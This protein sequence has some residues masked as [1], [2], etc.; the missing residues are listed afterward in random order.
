[1]ARPSGLASQRRISNRIRLFIGELTPL[2]AIVLTIGGLTIDIGH[3]GAPS[4]TASMA[5]AH[6]IGDHIIMA[7]VRTGAPMLTDSMV[8]APIMGGIARIGDIIMVIIPIGDTGATVFMVTL[9]GG[10]TFAA[11]PHAATSATG[12]MSPACPHQCVDTCPR[13][14]PALAAGI[15]AFTSAAACAVIKLTFSQSATL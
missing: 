4:P 13:E 1:V 5:T 15:D 2:T 6:I 9:L 7:T 11:S 10:V 12:I 3:I 8:I 14:M